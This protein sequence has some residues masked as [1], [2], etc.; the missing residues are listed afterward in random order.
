MPNK[1]S[2]KAKAVVPQPRPSR[3]GASREGNGHLVVGIGASAGG[4][5]A[6]RKLLD[7]MP[8]PNGMVFII[9]QHLEP[10]HDSL[11]VDLLASHTDMTVIQASDG[12]LIAPD[13]V[14]VIPPGRYLSCEGRTL[15]ITEPAER[16]GARMPIDFLLNSLALEFGARAVG[17][18]LSGTGSDGSAGVLAIKAKGGMVIVQESGEAG[19]DGMPTSAIAT[20]AAHHIL[21]LAKMPAILK[22][23]SSESK[24]NV[25]AAPIVLQPSAPDWL[26]D[27]IELLRTKTS[28]DFTLYKKGTLQRRIERRMALAGI[29]VGDTARYLDI[30]RGNVS[31]TENL[32]KDLLINV[33]Q[34]FRDPKAF[35][36]LGDT[37]IPELVKNQK[38]GMPL[39]VWIAGCSSGEEAYSLAILFREHVTASKKQIELQF[40]ASDVDADAVAI[41]REGKY[42]TSIEANVSPERI[43]RF[44][45]K[46]D[47]GYRVST[48]LRSTVIFTVQDVISDPPF[49]RLDMVSCRNLLIY[50]APE[51]QAKVI[52]LFHFALR[53]GGFLLLGSSETAG[54]IE[55]RFEVVSKPIRIYRNIGRG[56][57]GDIRL[58]A[59]DGSKPPPRA[60]PGQTPA[61]P[62]AMGELCR[63]LV[64]E[65]YAPAAVLINRKNQ[66]VFSMGPTDHYLRVSPG[67][68]SH[69]LLAMVPPDVRAKLKLAILQVFEN[70]SRTSV[71]GC[72]MRR[73]GKDVIFSIDLQL[74]PSDD[75]LLI[76]FIDT[77]KSVSKKSTDETPQNVAH[78]AELE[79]ELNAA[80]QELQTAVRDLEIS[81]EEQKAINEEASSVN[82]EYQSTNEELL[83]SKEELQSLNE[84][85]TA[86]NSQLQETLERQRSTSDDLQ[87]ILYS[88]N[89][90]TL[91]LDMNLNIRFFTPAT[92]SLFNV[93]PGDVGRPLTDLNSLSA[94]TALSTDA[95]AVL[96]DLNAIDR[97]IETGT[98]TWFMRRILPYRTHG[99]DVEGV[100][101]TF[102]DI[103]EKKR[104]RKDIEEA[105][106]QAEQANAG[107]SRF[108]AM[109]SHDLRQPLQT[110]A[111]LQGLLARA[112]E[113][114]KAH[115]LVSRLDETLSAMTGMLNT[116]LDINQI[117]AGNVQPV[118]ATFSVKDMLD[119]LRNEYTYQAH[120][121]GLSLRVVSGNYMVHSDPRLLEQM[122]R[123]LLSNAMKYTPKGK[124]LLGCRRRAGVVSIEIWDTGVGIAE[125]QTQAIFNEY[126]QIGNTERARSRGLGLGL[127]IVRR[128]GKLLGHQ[129]SVRSK[130]D[131]GSVFRIAIVP[132]LEDA[133]PQPDP[134]SDGEANA[135]VGHIRRAGTVL[136]VEDDPDVQVLLEQLLKDDGH[137]VMCAIDGAAALE[138]VA[139]G[140]IKPDVVLTDFNL[141]GSLN[142]LQMAAHL[143]EKLDAALPVIVLT[144]DIST[145]TLRDI[146]LQKCVQLNKP[147]KL[148]ELTQTVQRLLPASSGK[149]KTVPSVTKNTTTPVIFVVDDD[150]NIRVAMCTM[151]ETEGWKVQSFASCEAFLQSYRQGEHACLLVD[152]YLPGMNG[153]ELL[154]KLRDT[155]NSLPA[156]MITGS[157]DVAIAVQ[158]MKA[159]ASDFIEKPVSGSELVESIKRALDQSTDKNKLADWRKIATRHIAGLTARQ[160]QIMAMVLD[161]QPSKNIAADLNISQRTVEN[162]RSSIMK[163]TGAKSLPA[164]ARLALAATPNTAP[165]PL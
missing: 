49:S 95:R 52:S 35:E 94:D 39:R 142:G 155:G 130:P 3:E 18:I 77:P 131:K 148:H 104:T 97:E 1:A 62:T 46:D 82:E 56:P 60:S 68:P 9:V 158:A 43:A 99:D 92:K 122:I 83:T 128:L 41:A 61:T 72:R 50:L 134:P 11:M 17:I 86:L 70:R 76:C 57:V 78:V 23:H 156:I 129:V 150:A 73:E 69:D 151:L 159:G 75:L 146:S 163:R 153:L 157:S 145:K 37:I 126:H 66:C 124:V 93:I 33:T 113:G 116:L 123:N 34:F 164:L 54:D 149:V 90:A 15:R 16:H 71:A 38:P 44:F 84:E 88:T 161:G 64:L 160:R 132:S 28:H 81:G 96:R 144:G 125:N 118:M 89:V 48:E 111:L 24:P 42:P 107:K 85:L 20:G 12:M 101:I 67:L 19:Y 40:F 36:V 26:H 63:R 110:L 55:G 45:S 13:T 8:V 80:R 137:H 51:A 127:S 47:H 119:R 29:K 30:L 135:T 31:E 98:G 103:S 6:C 65:G 58:G 121:Q 108:L 102:T 4:L 59:G 117:E 140:L 21:A 115:K 147:V 25:K 87:N 32:A 141:P 91:F 133:K 106:L 154:Q 5:D 138:L 162:H 109:A 139:K 112:V 152:A 100:V 79:L 10:N 165:T 74:V 22:A 136:I 120:A 27:I 53:K 2:P 114:E 7:E 143:R 14:Y 105:R